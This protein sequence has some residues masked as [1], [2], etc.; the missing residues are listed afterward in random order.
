MLLWLLDLGRERFSIHWQ[1]YRIYTDMVGLMYRVIVADQGEFSHIMYL[2]SN[3]SDRCAAGQ[4]EQDGWIVVLSE[5][6]LSEYAHNGHEISKDSLPLKKTSLRDFLQWTG[7]RTDLFDTEYIVCFRESKSHLQAFLQPVMIGE[8]DALALQLFLDSLKN[9]SEIRTSRLIESN[10][11]E[12]TK[13]VN[14][15][16]DNQTSDVF[17]MSMSA[18]C[19][20]LSHD[21]ISRELGSSKCSQLFPP[22]P[23]VS[24]VT[25][26]LFDAITEA[27]ELFGMIVISTPSNI[28]EF[29]NSFNWN[30]MCH[31]A[32]EAGLRILQSNCY[33]KHDIFDRVFRMTLGSSQKWLSCLD[34]IDINAHADNSQDIAWYLLAVEKVLILLDNRRRFYSFGWDACDKE[35]LFVL[36][37]LTKFANHHFEHFQQILHSKELIEKYQPVLCL[38]S[39]GLLRQNEVRYENI[40]KTIYGLC[41]QLRNLELHCDFLL[42]PKNVANEISH[43]NYND[44]RPTIF[45]IPSWTKQLANLGYELVGPIGSGCNGTVYQ[46]IELNTGQFVAIKVSE[47]TPEFVS[48]AIT[49]HVTSC[50]FDSYSQ[51]FSQS[52]ASSSSSS[53]SGQSVEGEANLLKTIRHTNI[54]SVKD[55]FTI[56]TNDDFTV[57]SSSGEKVHGFMVMEFCEGGSLHNHFKKSS[58]WGKIAAIKHFGR[59]V[60]QG[61]MY[62]HMRHMV[63]GDLKPENVLISSPDLLTLAAVAKLADFGMAHVS[64]RMHLSPIGL[65]CY[66]GYVGTVSYMAPE[67]LRGNKPSYKSD[68]WSFGCILQHL[69]TG[70]LPWSHI[71]SD[72]NI[73]FTIGAAT[74]SFIRENIVMSNNE[75]LNTIMKACLNVQVNCRPS[76][77]TLLTNKFF[78]SAE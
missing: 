55:V 74:D 56:G 41:E 5:G 38:Q 25:K 6:F 67:V 28:G 78:K 68:I 63:H 35:Y 4:V 34:Q 54:V 70:I 47:I 16:F 61:L 22:N 49:F 69:L 59:N 50:G 43:S 46:A 60:L 40:V 42:K 72:W 52:T 29:M 48:N 12:A 26:R 76:S 62:L 53:S 13:L 9:T 77:L 24:P 37:Q 39:L 17:I 58:L 73:I 11:N 57:S 71:G 51:S 19:V 75:E 27:E 21:S 32:V 65:G 8:Q 45:E 66:G 2:L 23:D 31:V 33:L 36:E 44:L 18:Y 3:A 15:D 30:E 14:L 7:E 20:Q 10:E 1:F 64:D